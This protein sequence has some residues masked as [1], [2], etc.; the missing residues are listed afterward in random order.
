MTKPPQNSSNKYK[1][2]IHCAEDGGW[3]LK[4][5]SINVDTKE[6]FKEAIEEARRLVTF[7]FGPNKKL[8]KP[9]KS[10]EPIQLN[11]K[12]KKLLEKLKVKRN[13]IANEKGFP[14]YIVANNRTLELFASKKP[15]TK[16]EMLEI[17]GM[18]EKKFQDYG[19]IFL[20]EIKDFS[21]D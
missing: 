12:D 17:A 5:I 19:V 13:E 21:E 14:S 7:G 3:Y 8:S 1:I 6:E 18:G 9:K 16:S 10:I 15:K 20:K 11:E 4:S 2:N